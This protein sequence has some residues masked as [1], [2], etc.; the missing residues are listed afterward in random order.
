MRRGVVDLGSN[1]FHALVADVDAF[2]MR[3]V[4]FDRKRAIRIGAHAFAERH[5]PDDA[6][7]SGLD[8]IGELITHARSRVHDHCRVIATGVFRD[9]DNGPAFLAE[10]SA[11]NGIAIELLDG[12]EEARLTWT[13]VSAELAGSHGRLAVLDLGG[14]S[15]ELAAGNERADLV[16]SLPLGALRLRELTAPGAREAVH[17][18][19]AVALA[20][21]SAYRPETVA[22]ASGTARALLAVA[23]RLGLVG[24]ASRYLST[25]VFAELARRLA[26]LAPEALE[27]LGVS[28]HRRDT[29]G[30][31]AV[32]LAAALE[33]I[34][35]PVVFVARSALREGALIDAERASSSMPRMRLLA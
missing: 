3:N 6:Y 18:V 35:S 12:G 25:R 31:G 13:G 19:A 10:A 26:W 24:N 15:L 5:I 9:T 16:H 22:V 14:G 8:A 4:V 21:V 1:T 34:D 17:A 23:R 30:I 33:L 29:I 27:A 7:R 20:Q 2:G 11:R 28:K 32:V